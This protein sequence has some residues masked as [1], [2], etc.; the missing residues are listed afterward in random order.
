MVNE[1]EIEEV[2]ESQVIKKKS[3]TEKYKIEEDKAL[4][5]AWVNIFLDVTHLNCL[6]LC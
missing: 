4:C 6:R 1:I 5:G 2:E 3:W